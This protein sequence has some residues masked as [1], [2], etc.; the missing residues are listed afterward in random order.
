MESIKKNLWLVV[1][2]AVGL[3]LLIVACVFLFLHIRQYLADTHSADMEQSRLEQLEQRRLAGPTE[4]NVHILATNCVALEGCLKSVLAQLRQG[5]VEPRKMQPV[6]FNSFL[7]STIDQMNEAAKRQGLVV[8]AKFDYGFKTYYIEGRL[9]AAVD[10]PRLTIQVQTVKALMDL[11][12]KAKITEVTGIE[13][14]VFEQ[15]LMT[16]A[17]EM[18][19]AGGGAHKATASAV[20]GA[21]L[22]AQLYT[23]EHFV[24]HL[25]VRDEMIAGLLNLFAQ[26]NEAETPRL[27]AVVTKL[28]LAGPGLPKTVTS[29]EAP[30]ATSATGEKTTEPKKREERIVA[31]ADSMA[32][33]LGVDIYRFTGET[34][35]KNKP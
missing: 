35:E 32:L 10:V 31:G 17:P 1:G 16:P 19:G 34:G 33:Q 24:L 9:P 27:F 20:A 18:T 14:Q 28:E 25:R 26:N 13:R 5:Q 12:R 7:K 11:L 21:S 15:G 4:E 2:G 30:G 29:V 3:V 22:E 8:P 6:D 23:H